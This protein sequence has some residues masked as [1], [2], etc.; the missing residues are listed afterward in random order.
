[1]VFLSFLL[2]ICKYLII[3]YLPISDHNWLQINETVDWGDYCIGFLASV[4]IRI[5]GFSG[6]WAN[7]WMNWDHLKESSH[8]SEMA[9]DWL[10]LR[11]M[12]IS[13]S[14]LSPFFMCVFFFFSVLQV[15]H[16]LN[17]FLVGQ[18]EGLSL[19][20][21]LAKVSWLGQVADWLNT[22]IISYALFSWLQNNWFFPRSVSH[23]GWEYM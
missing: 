20:G 6:V 18:S 14:T 12:F 21:G 2:S 17:P 4:E 8:S 13:V 15:R 16:E 22:F 23:V 19:I 9:V 10:A 3:L 11:D 7:A 5:G 1:M